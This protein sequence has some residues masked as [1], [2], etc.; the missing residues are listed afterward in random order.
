M[1]RITIYKLLKKY[2]KWYSYNG[3][4]V[5]VNPSLM[6]MISHPTCL[7]RFIVTEDMS[8]RDLEA[9]FLFSIGSMM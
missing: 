3:F 7:R 8:T 9:K 1:N 6:I 2:H 5:T 4:T